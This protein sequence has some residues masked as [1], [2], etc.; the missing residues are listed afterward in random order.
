[1][2]FPLYFLLILSSLHKY[3]MLTFFFFSLC[4]WVA[5]DPKV[6]EQLASG[7]LVQH[8]SRRHGGRY[9]DDHDHRGHHRHGQTVRDI[10]VVDGEKNDLMK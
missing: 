5:T 2:Y 10:I 7:N 3:I 8:R 9:R 6:G 4:V 1:M